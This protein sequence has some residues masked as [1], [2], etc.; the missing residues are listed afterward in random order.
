M[1]K[2]VEDKALEEY[3]GKAGWIDEEGNSLLSGEWDEYFRMIRLYRQK[4]L[5]QERKRA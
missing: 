5:R 1:K 4:S 3:A 2:C